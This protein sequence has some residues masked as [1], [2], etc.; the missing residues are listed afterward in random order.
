[1]I[2][3]WLVLQEHLYSHRP[4]RWRKQMDALWKE[5]VLFFYSQRKKLYFCELH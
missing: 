5:R 3:W 1:M 4:Y 2:V